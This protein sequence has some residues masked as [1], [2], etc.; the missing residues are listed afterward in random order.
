MNETGYINRLW[1]E[2]R[3]K[4][5][6]ILLVAS[7]A[8]LEAGHSVREGG[9]QSE[10]QHCN[11][12]LVAIFSSSK[13]N[14]TLLS[15]SFSSFDTLHTH[16]RRHLSLLTLVSCFWCLFLSPFLQTIAPEAHIYCP[17]LLFICTSLHPFLTCQVARVT[18]FPSSPFSLAP[19]TSPMVDFVSALFNSQSSIDLFTRDS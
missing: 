1:Y 13:R 4:K 17:H 9:G 18:S 5:R 14:F 2:K 10:I 3:S 19:S 12:T 7:L 6:K 8:H 11:L 15:Q 16:S